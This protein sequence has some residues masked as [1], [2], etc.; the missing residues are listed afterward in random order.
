MAALFQAAELVVTAVMGLPMIPI[1]GQ[2]AGGLSCPFFFYLEYEK[3]AS[4]VILKK[5]DPQFQFGTFGLWGAW[6]GRV[7]MAERDADR[8][9]GL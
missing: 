5:P 9:S 4:Y 6:N 1:R 7:G 3:C 8:R 2:F